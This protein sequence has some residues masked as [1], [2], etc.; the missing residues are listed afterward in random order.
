MKDT[1]EHC[2]KSNK[3]AL[4]KAGP[5]TTPPPTAAGDVQKITKN[6]EVSPN[7]YSH[8]HNCGNNIDK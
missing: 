8:T 5:P 1:K 6:Q 4:T 2:I 7:K 3:G